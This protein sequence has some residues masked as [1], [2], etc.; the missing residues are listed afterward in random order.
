MHKHYSSNTHGHY[1]QYVGAATLNSPYSELVTW[2]VVATRIAS[3]N[4]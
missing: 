4:L 2:A 3:L 1:W